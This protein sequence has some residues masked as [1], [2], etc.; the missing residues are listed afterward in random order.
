M[1]LTIPKSYDFFCCS[2]EF[3]FYF[4]VLLYF[5]NYCCC[6]V[7]FVFYAWIGWTLCRI[8]LAEHLST[9][10]EM[11]RSFYQQKKW[12]TLWDNTHRLSFGHSIQFLSMS[13]WHWHIHEYS[14]YF[15]F[16]NIRRV[17][18]ELKLIFSQLRYWTASNYPKEEE[19]ISSNRKTSTKL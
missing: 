6:I 1:G 10:V 9:N 7:S 17:W 2:Y 11:I 5:M 14:L 4:F 19:R 15:I 8:E 18:T 3:L 12:H 16:G 13:I